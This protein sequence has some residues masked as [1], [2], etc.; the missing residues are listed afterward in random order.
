[1]P[2]RVQ[3][4][5]KEVSVR[6]E[7]GT[8]RAIC[9]DRTYWL[10]PVVDVTFTSIV[11]DDA[12]KD[13]TIP[14]NLCEWE[15][16]SLGSSVNFT[17]R[18]TTMKF[19]VDQAANV[20]N[21]T[22]VTPS[23]GDVCE[24][25]INFTDD[26]VKSIITVIAR[27]NSEEGPMKGQQYMAYVVATGKACAIRA[28]VNFRFDET[29]SCFAWNNGGW[30]AFPALQKVRGS[31]LK[32]IDIALSKETKLV[33]P[34]KPRTLV[35]TI[36]YVDTELRTIYVL[37]SKSPDTCDP[38]RVM[39]A[40][41]FR[42]RVC[43]ITY[44]HQ[45]LCIDNANEDVVSL[46]WCTRNR[47]RVLRITVTNPRNT[48]T[49]F[50]RTVFEGCLTR[51][52]FEAYNVLNCSIV[53]AFRK[54]RK[55]LVPYDV[56]LNEYKSED[57]SDAESIDGR[58]R[59]DR[60]QSVS[61]VR[62]CITAYFDCIAKVDDDVAF[63]QFWKNHMRY[64]P[65]D[66]WDLTE[67][68]D[69]S[70]LFV[71]F[72]FPSGVHELDLRSWRFSWYILSTNRMF[73][74]VKNLRTVFLPE[75]SLDVPFSMQQRGGLANAVNVES[76]FAHSSI[77]RVSV[78]LKV[79]RSPDFVML[80]GMFASCKFLELIDLNIKFQGIV[81]KTQFMHMNNFASTCP[82]LHSCRINMH[83]STG[84]WATSVKMCVVQASK[85]FQR[86]Y[87]LS[88][89]AF[90]GDMQVA[91]GTDDEHG[92]DY[93]QMLEGCHALPNV[94]VTN[95]FRFLRLFDLAKERDVDCVRGLLHE[96]GQNVDDEP[97][98]VN[99]ELSM[100]TSSSSEMAKLLCNMLGTETTT[101]STKR[102][103]VVVA[104]KDNV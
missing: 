73:Y 83:V 10:R 29:K 17:S 58:R 22:M 88:E 1:M 95:M 91:T 86:C 5:F 24:C 42:A 35:S 62:K 49:F 43:A 19:H 79:S 44:I 3:Y 75:L 61:D 74:N 51:S 66:E 96:T 32:R 4:V 90:T 55:L 93:K 89:L 81:S 21:I 99:K 28:D 65:I 31:L 9:M 27:C 23:G 39:K 98:V 57:D 41:G 84:E 20:M 69:L 18:Y 78:T 56:C 80:S 71:D 7:D 102:C 59:Y 40:R 47:V 63:A 6:N 97:L 30:Q 103:V 34:G 70:N 53:P 11:N 54:E 48:D 85:A 25:P 12:E 104:K 67:L 76:M 46:E 33:V 15:L 94:A 37:V 50:E 64:G 60:F 36:G 14:F 26:I 8:S 92:V 77:E 16:A 82:I 13:V 87:E 45:N 101:N 2:T 68:T 72:V 38:S 100:T 52:A